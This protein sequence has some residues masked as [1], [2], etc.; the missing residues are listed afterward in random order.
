[1]ARAEGRINF[2]KFNK[3]MSCVG[4]PRVSGRGECNGY[5]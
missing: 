2:K 4:M 5:G 3:K 1:M